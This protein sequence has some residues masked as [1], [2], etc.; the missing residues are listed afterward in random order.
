MSDVEDTYGRKNLLIRLIDLLAFVDR[1]HRRIDDSML[2]HFLLERRR[3][4]KRR[5]SRR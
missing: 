1:V 4:R 2:G 3:A 5:K